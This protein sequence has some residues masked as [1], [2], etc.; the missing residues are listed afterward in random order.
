MQ[1]LLPRTAARTTVLWLLS[2]VAVLA[3][4]P[5][6]KFERAFFLEEHKQDFAA[7]QKLYAEVAADGSADAAL[8]SEA[9]GRSA[10]CR[11]EAATGDL[12]QL[13]PASAW[14]YVQLDRPSEQVLRLLDQLGLLRGATD[15]GQKAARQL[16]ISPEIV[17]QLLGVRGVAACI[18]GFDAVH[19][20]P[21]GVAVIHPGRLDVLRALL[22]TALPIQFEPSDPIDGFTTYEIE[23]IYVT[24]T[25]RLI[26]V[27]PSEAEIEGVVR[28]LGGDTSDSLASNPEMADALRQRTDAL[29]VAAVNFKP[30]IP[31]I[32]A[33]IAAASAHEPELAAMSTLA[34][35]R[36]LKTFVFR[37]GVASDGIFAS[38]SLELEKGHR[39]LIFNLL[40]LPPVDQT[41]LRYVPQG[42][43]GFLTF[44]LNP[45]N[46]PLRPIYT[47]AEEVAPPPVTLLDLGREVFGNLVGVTL[48]TLPS[49][50]PIPGEREPM[51]DAAA[52]LTVNDPKKSIAL[53]EQFLGIMN[54]AGGGAIEGSKVTFAGAAARKYSIPE[55]GG[56][57]FLATHGNA[58]VLTASQAA[59]ERTLATMNGGKSIA[60]DPAFSRAISQITPDSALAAVAH[61]G[62]CMELASGFMRERDVKEIKPFAEM[63]S[64]TVGAVVLEHSPTSLGLSLRVTG[65]P[66]VS[67]LVAQLIERERSGMATRSVMRAPM[68]TIDAAEAQL[69]EN[70][71]NF[72]PIRRVFESQVRGG[73][74]ASATGERFFQAAGGDA[75]A[76]ND[77]AWALLTESKY[78]GRYGE[79]ALKCSRRSNE[80]TDHS[81]WMYVDTLAHAYFALGQRDKAIELERKA[82]K[83]CGSDPR[84]GEVEAALRRFEAADAPAARDS[85]KVESVEAVRHP[86][87]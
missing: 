46:K 26:V 61:A 85:V 57:I 20:R 7:A 47:E 4:T 6:Q 15:A 2:A 75:R 62:R 38:G 8:R 18:T 84:R 39:N 65:L 64:R 16:A 80:L 44:S 24:L 35:V 21:A 43:A 50:S 13:M 42:A 9:K 49:V 72:E 10:A 53:W 78:Q 55:T 68:T 76:L 56:S 31:L 82:L 73:G 54:L 40:R 81:D 45:S 77:F 71:K 36:S 79:L 67:G 69:A 66:N 58:V 5:Q 51:P 17:E 34:D 37:A 59:L 83:L 11:E 74:D 29:L 70:P 30:L 87:R 22:E 52:I 33:G 19:E 41:A 14:A 25:N 1:P 86:D 12:A 23:G 3:D 60:D 63:A 48:F 28:R 32:Q 27:S